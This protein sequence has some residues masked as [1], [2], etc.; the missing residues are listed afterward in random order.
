MKTAFIVKD[1]WISIEKKS[2]NV[3]QRA[4]L[5]QES[6][7]LKNTLLTSLCAK[8]SNLMRYYECGH[9]LGRYFGDSI[10]NVN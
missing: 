1:V 6:R 3:I 10:S 9:Y 2:A 5:H 8:R 4:E 7:P